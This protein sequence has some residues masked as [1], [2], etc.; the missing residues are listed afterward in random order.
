MCV[1]RLSIHRI[2]LA[3]F[4]SVAGPY[5]SVASGQSSPSGQSG[6]ASQSGAAGNSQ[7]AKSQTG[8]PKPNA[9]QRVTVQETFDPT[10]KI[11]PLTQRISGRGGEVVAFKFM[12]ESANQ[13]ADIEVVP[14][15]LRQD[16]SGLILNDDSA[17]VADLVRLVTPAK[18]TLEP[19]KSSWVEGVV[20]IPKGDDQFHTIGLLIRDMGKAPG[21]K[22]GVDENGQPITQAAVRFMT[23]YIVRLDL[24]VEGVRGD[25]AAKAVIDD[26][27]I[28]PSRGRPKLQLIVANPTGTTFEFELKARLRSSPSDRSFTPLRLVVPIRASIETDERYTARILPKCRLRMEEWLPEAIPSGRYE[29]DLELAVDGRVV[30]RRTI[31]VDVDSEDFPAQEVLIA[32]AADG[33]QVSPAQIEL[34]QTRGGTRRLTMLLKNSGKQAKTIDLRAV[35]ASDLELPGV[36]VQ[37][38]QVSLPAGASRKVVVTMR[39][40]GDTTQPVDYG[41]MVVECRSQE[42]EFVETKRLPLAIIYRPIGSTQIS[43]DP[44]VWDDGGRYPR[45]RTQVRN[46]GDKH[47]PMDARLSI[48]SSNGL[49]TVLYGG[50]GKW[51]MPGSKGELEFRVESTLPPGDYLLKFELQTGGEPATMEQSFR[52]NDPTMVVN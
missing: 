34:S 36:Q 30:S 33:L 6:Q 19:N 25:S 18:M 26:L 22:P 52:V 15:G 48:S 32:Q 47:L 39:G 24:V 7:A 10:F 31:P 45:F 13:P 46:E 5:V 23:Q 49:R 3:V 8:N 40:R 43:V 20:Q 4:V 16:L 11:E 9:R 2:V 21:L 41:Q 51:L 38:S 14:V 12:I 42:K 27:S 17:E 28:V 37:P 35:T 44:V 29:A 50:F 1:S